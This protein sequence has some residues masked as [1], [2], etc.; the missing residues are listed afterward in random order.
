MLKSVVK[1]T[2][3][4]KTLFHKLL[5][6]LQHSQALAFQLTGY[7]SLF[8]IIKNEIL[9]AIRRYH[10]VV[11]E[12]IIFHYFLTLNDQLIN[13]KIIKLTV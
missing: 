7:Y 6:L 2:S 13:C 1:M 11:W 3:L 10:Y 9:I 5:L 8:Y 12:V 4:A